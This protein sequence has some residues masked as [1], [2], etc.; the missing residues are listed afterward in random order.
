MQ[1]WCEHIIKR[2]PNQDRT[3]WKVE[4]A[5]CDGAQTVLVLRPGVLTGLAHGR[6]AAVTR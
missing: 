3:A 4:P 5:L 1:E 6:Y 2:K